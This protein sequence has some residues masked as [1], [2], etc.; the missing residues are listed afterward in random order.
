[1]SKLPQDSP[2]RGGTLNTQHALQKTHVLNLQIT[3]EDLVL[4]INKLSAP[5]LASIHTGWEHIHLPKLQR[6]IWPIHQKVLTYNLTNSKSRC[7]KDQLYT[8]E[9]E[10]IIPGHLK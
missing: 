1:M 5:H 3:R 9:P 8:H 6:H 10:N 2:I 7:Q 4:L